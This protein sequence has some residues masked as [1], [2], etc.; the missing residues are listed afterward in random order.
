MEQ[1]FVE[2]MP[3]QDLPSEDWCRSALTPTSEVSQWTTVW[4][5]DYFDMCDVSPDSE[6]VKVNASTKKDVYDKYVSEMTGIDTELKPMNYPRFLELWATVYPYCVKRTHCQ[7]PGKCAICGYIDKQRRTA[8]DRMTLLFLKKAHMMH[9][10]GMFMQERKRYAYSFIDD[11]HFSDMIF[12]DIKR[13][14]LLRCYPYSEA[15]IAQC[16]LL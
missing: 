15:I 14:F 5:Q 3:E 4:M 13:E 12:V 6:F 2:N 1:I 11:K 16:L 10:G 7:I 9:R 8:C